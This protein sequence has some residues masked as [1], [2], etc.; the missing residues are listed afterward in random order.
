MSTIWRPEPAAVRPDD[1]GEEHLV[2]NQLDLGLGTMSLDRVDQLDD[3]KKEIA[4]R[5][6]RTTALARTSLEVVA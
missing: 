2:L 4:V 1:R 6:H 3:V 5:I